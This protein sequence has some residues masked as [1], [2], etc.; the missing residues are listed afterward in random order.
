MANTTLGIYPA[1]Q[2]KNI[3]VDHTGPASYTTGGETFGNLNNQ[4]G[5]TLLG[6]AVL[7]FV[8]VQGPS[9]SGNYSAVVQITGT[10]ER[11]TCKIIWVTATAGIPSTTQVTAAT[12]LSGETIRLMVTGR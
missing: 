8:D 7:D 9:V 11:K 5:I 2:S 6:L 1:G 10:G 4:T 12:N 3:I